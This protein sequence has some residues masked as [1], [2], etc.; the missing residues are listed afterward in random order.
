MPRARPTP[1]TRRKKTPAPTVRKLYAVTISASVAHGPEMIVGVS[2]NTV[3]G[4]LTILQ[5]KDGHATVWPRVF[6]PG[7]WLAMEQVGE[8]AENLPDTEMP[9]TGG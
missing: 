2:F 6:A 8:E 4:A 5:P 1:T 7:T 9:E 3:G